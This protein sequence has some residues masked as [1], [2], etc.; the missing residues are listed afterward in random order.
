MATSLTMTVR[1]M[2]VKNLKSR[3]ERHEY[4][5]DPQAVAEALLVRHARC[6]YPASVVSP[7]APSSASPAGPFVTRPIR[8]TDARPGGP[9]TRS[10]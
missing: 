8:V 4:R 1:T 10:S 3:V 6:W 7:W 2:L 5:I 9:H